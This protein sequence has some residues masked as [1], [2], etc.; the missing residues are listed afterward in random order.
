[1]QLPRILLCHPQFRYLEMPMRLTA[2]Y[3]QSDF[4]NIAAAVG[5][6]VGAVKP[7]ARE[8]EAAA[9]AYRLAGSPFQRRS[10]S[11]LKSKLQQIER[12]AQ[13]LLSHLGVS[14]PSDALDGPGDLEILH[15]LTYA[16]GGDED[17]VIDATRRIGRL[18]EIIQ[19]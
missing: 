14:H 4:E 19:S 3:V 15:V 10:P 12:S 18:A 11:Q 5:S 6:S 13:R 2:N 17:G 16:E 9:S 7:Y 1:M 8:F